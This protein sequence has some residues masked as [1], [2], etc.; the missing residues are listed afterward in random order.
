[1]E[2]G[3]GKG[4]PISVQAGGKGKDSIIVSVSILTMYFPFDSRIHLFNISA[5]SDLP[6]APTPSRGV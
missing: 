6:V 3:K 5:K 2:A 4:V 1:M